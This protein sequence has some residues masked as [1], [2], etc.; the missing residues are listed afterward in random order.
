MAEDINSTFLALTDPLEAEVDELSIRFDAAGQDQEWKD[1]FHNAAQRGV[2][3]FD[4]AI[5][6]LAKYGISDSVL[7]EDYTT[8]GIDPTE[9]E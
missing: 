4:A 5:S 1:I 2:F 7:F 3:D 9:L 8:S 6:L